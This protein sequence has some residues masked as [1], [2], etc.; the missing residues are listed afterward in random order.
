M[1]TK[2]MEVVHMPGKD[3]VYELVDEN[4]RVLDASNRRRDLVAKMHA[5]LHLSAKQDKK[6]K[7]SDLKKFLIKK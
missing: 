1:N 4:G 2:S 6:P 3:K 7:K 5:L